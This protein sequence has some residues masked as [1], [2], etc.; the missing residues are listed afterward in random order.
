VLALELAIEL[1]L[2][3]EEDDSPT[4]PIP[5]DELVAE[6]SPPADA[7][8][9]VDAVE[10]AEE[11]P[12][13]PPI[14]LE[15][16]EEEDDATV[17]SAV[18]L[19]EEADAPPIPLDDD[20]EV[21][22]P[23]ELAVVLDV[24]ALDPAI[25]ELVAPA[26]PAA[27]WVEPLRPS[28]L[29]PPEPPR[30]VDELP[31]AGTVA[32]RAAP[33]ANT[34]EL[35]HFKLRSLALTRL[36]RGSRLGAQGVRGMGRDSTCVE[37]RN[38]GRA[39]ACAVPRARRRKAARAERLLRTSLRRVC[40]L[41]PAR[42]RGGPRRRMSSRPMS[43]CFLIR[44]RDRLAASRDYEAALQ[45]RR[46]GRQSCRVPRGAPLRCRPMRPLAAPI[47]AT[48]SG[49]LGFGA[50]ESVS[51]L[52]AEART[53]FIAGPMSHIHF[54]GGEK[55]G[56]GKSVV[57]RLLAQW[58]VDRSIPFAAVDGD[59]SH[60]A[61]SRSY[62]DFT[63]VLDLKELSNADMIIDRALGA[64]RRV[65]IDLPAQSIRSLR[66][67]IASANVLGFARETGIRMSFWHVTDGGFASVGEM[68]RALALFGDHFEHK[69]VKNFGRSKDFTQFD[70]SSTKHRLEEL[71][72]KTVQLA[73]LDATAMY[74]ID[75]LG[76]SFWAAV[77]GNDGEG[78]KPLE[79]QR[80]RLWLDRFYSQVE[81]LGDA[82]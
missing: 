10:V 41:F 77:H 15:D 36:S 56:V 11:E 26:P 7:V 8:E 59:L 16:A 57:A 70:Q 34:K 62:T 28:S 49:L 71:G 3:A 47:L 42:G 22:S 4:P 31:H 63:Q 76:V 78:L 19:V 6:P 13:A 67:W 79:R 73:E 38:S 51:D 64:E 9:V 14:P 18:L 53:A 40:G 46:A 12:V 24:D 1:V 58:F 39:T 20:A 60:G 2:E 66:D 44:S 23:E 65:L 35:H 21:D 37:H 54:I 45:S 61:L 43:T 72:S 33:K 25:A 50:F 80:V 68:D 5:L 82:I 55:G 17:L 29:D 27:A 74:K 30:L 75:R 81:A 52:T 69:V 48:L 32:R